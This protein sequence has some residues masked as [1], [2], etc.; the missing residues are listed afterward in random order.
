MDFTVNTLS[1][2]T[3]G[4][5]YISSKLSDS[6]PRMFRLC[7]KQDGTLVLQGG[8]YWSKGFTESGLEW[9]DLETVNE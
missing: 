9:V 4:F 5:E 1:L 2:P 8:Y 6:T 3:G 7:K